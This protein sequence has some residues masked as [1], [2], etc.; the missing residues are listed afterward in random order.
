MFPFCDVV[1]AVALFLVPLVNAK[2]KIK[3]KFKGATSGSIGSEQALHDAVDETTAASKRFLHP[4]T[5]PSSRPSRSPARS[6][7]PPRRYNSRDSTEDSSGRSGSPPASPPMSPSA[8][9]LRT[10]NPNRTPSAP[11]SAFAF[12]SPFSQSTSEQGS[13]SHVTTPEDSPAGS[14]KR[15]GAVDPGSHN[16]HLHA[17]S[18]PK[19][20]T[21]YIPLHNHTATFKR[22]IHCPVSISL[23]ALP[24]GRYQLQ[25]S[26][27]KLS[28]R[29]EITGDE[30]K[31]E[32]VRT[33]EVILDLAQFVPSLGKNGHS[34]QGQA[35]RYLLQDCKTNATL[36]VTVQMEFLGG[37]QNYVA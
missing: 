18:E 5:I 6:T 33:G 12:T 23:K 24:G 14:S 8:A 2:F 15:R 25:P 26:S 4:L 22:E 27:V 17:R 36:K 37:E 21:S 1:N 16:S 30:G 10:P 20:T 9:E 34:G 7:S 35:R 32:E 31:K 28:V 29:Q 3:W 11:S 13:W 19:G